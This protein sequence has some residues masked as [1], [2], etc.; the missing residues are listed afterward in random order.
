MVAGAQA[1]YILRENNHCYPSV[2]CYADDMEGKAITREM[3]T[4]YHATSHEIAACIVA[5][6]FRGG[7][8]WQHS[9]VVF[10]AAEPLQGFGDVWVAL[11]VPAAWLR[12]ADR[13]DDVECEDDRGLYYCDVW[14]VGARGLNR[15]ARN[16]RM[17]TCSDLIAQEREDAALALP[18]GDE[19]DPRP[20]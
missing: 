19:Q 4:V 14:C 12:S 13:Y 5:R 9:A 18:S 2:V 17:I 3:T 7:D 1:P 20:F 11:D 6:A 16:K 15:V 10:L 8:V